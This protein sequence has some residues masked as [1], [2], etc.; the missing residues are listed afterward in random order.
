[1]KA[2]FYHIGPIG[3]EGRTITDA[4]IDAENNASTALAGSYDPFFAHY[5]KLNLVVWR[6][7]ATGWTYRIIENSDSPFISKALTLCSISNDDR[8]TCIAHALLHMAQLAWSGENEETCELLA[9]LPR[10]QDDYTSWVRFQKGYR[11]AKLHGLNDNEAHNRA[12]E[13][14]RAA[15]FLEEGAKSCLG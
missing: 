3:G 12:M 5:R 2:K 14:Y 7:P 8:E 10:M 6:F 15:C 4:K 1:M 9:S 11:I 13:F